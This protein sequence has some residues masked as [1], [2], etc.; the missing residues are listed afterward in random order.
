MVDE[1]FEAIFEVL[2]KKPECWTMD[3]VV[4][5]LKL[6][7]MDKYSDKFR[8]SDLKQAKTQ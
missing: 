4:E 6:I 5:W 3:D 7:N 1:R 8:K 2:P